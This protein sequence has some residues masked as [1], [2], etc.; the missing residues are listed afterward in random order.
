MLRKLVSKAVAR[1]RWWPQTG[2]RNGA[3]AA[4]QALAW[5]RLRL[6]ADT[7]YLLVALLVPAVC[8]L[9]RL[10]TYPLRDNNE[11]LYAEVAREMLAT[12]QYVVPHLNGLPYLEKPPLLYWLMSLSMRL[13]GPTVEAVRLVSALSMLGI[14]VA[15]FL[16]CRRHGN[17]RAGCIASVILG[18]AL[19]VVVL[20]H[21]VL[22]DPL[23]TALLGASLL[24]YL[25]S[26]LARSARARRV[27]AF[28]LALAVLEKGAV[29]LALAGGTVGLFLL[30]MR[31]RAA[32]R[33]LLDPRAW[34]ILLLIAVPWHVAAA[35]A[36]P[37]F[38]WFYF[39]NEHLLRFLGRR[40]PI[41]YHHGPLWYYV[42]RL[43]LLTFPWTPFLVLLVRP[44]AAPP[45]ANRVMLRFC[46]AAVLFPFLF[47]SLSEG[48]ADYYLL[49][50]MP[51][52]ALWLGLVIAR[53]LQD[54]DRRVPACWGVALASLCAAAM[55]LPRQEALRSSLPLAGLLV[56][57]CVAVALAATA[58]FRHLRTVQQREGALLAI[59]V[60]GIAVLVLAGR[61]VERKCWQDSCRDLAR[62][63]HRHPG[64]EP[65]VFVYRDFEDVFSTL[66]FYLGRT[67]PVIDSASNDLLFGCTRQPGRQCLTLGQFEHTRM[68]GPVAVA[69]R[70]DRVASFLALTGRRGWRIEKLG[71]K[72][73]L[74]SDGPASGPRQAPR[75][76]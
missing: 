54:A 11:G 15:L 53:S 67:V 52:L 64:R 9:A 26:Y 46:Q 22:F 73:V 8:F 17:P 6:D 68:A 3:L 19:P 66:P 20:G 5:P 29:A 40:V 10:D 35:M 36:Q 33:D 61:K 37:G 62:M 14:C 71:D 76:A 38:G 47:F 65:A 59:V 58:G 34:A 30:W 63:I 45:P 27:A 28:L 4:A 1:P 16:F 23:L 21:L 39:V 69:V 50:V 41:D 25:H 32:W 57:L 13:F 7:V 2:P 48:K 74:F 75:R 42:P 43:L 56:L 12:G 51:A 31:E 55:A 18:S 49:V 70:A 60:L 24:C 72:M 44:G